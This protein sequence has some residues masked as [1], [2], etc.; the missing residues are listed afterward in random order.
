MCWQEKGDVWSVACGRN[1]F[2]QLVL[3]ITEI[4]LSISTIFSCKIL[5]IFFFFNEVVCLKLFLSQRKILRRSISQE[6]DQ[7]MLEIQHYQSL[8]GNFFLKLANISIFKL[9]STTSSSVEICWNVQQALVEQHIWS[10]R[11]FQSDIRIFN[12]FLGK[13]L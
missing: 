3:N 2:K 6:Y 8:C 1:I 13:F 11:N 7:K 5:T 10:L 4:F 12:H 9:S